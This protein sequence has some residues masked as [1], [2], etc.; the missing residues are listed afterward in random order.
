[1]CSIEIRTGIAT[2]GALRQRKL[3]I[4]ALDLNV[5]EGTNWI[6]ERVLLIHAAQPTLSPPSPTVRAGSRVSLAA[7]PTLRVGLSPSPTARL[8]GHDFEF[9]VCFSLGTSRF[10]SDPLP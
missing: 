3:L 7:A 8:E 9:F 5:A 1:M 6:Y 10:P 2:V 4:K